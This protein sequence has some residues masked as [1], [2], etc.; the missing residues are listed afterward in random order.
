MKRTKI[1]L[2]EKF[3]KSKV[4]SIIIALQDRGGFCDCEV[5]ANVTL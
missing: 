3:S 2:E 4:K 1:Y 5:L